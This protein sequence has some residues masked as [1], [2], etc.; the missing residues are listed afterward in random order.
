MTKIILLL[1]MLAI[2]ALPFA[3]LKLLEHL[4]YIMILTGEEAQE[5]IKY[6]EKKV[7]KGE[8]AVDI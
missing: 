6:A 5:F 1:L 7:K 3:I 8:W 4:G 2:L